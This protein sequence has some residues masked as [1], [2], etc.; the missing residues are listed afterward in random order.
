MTQK[1]RKNFDKTTTFIDKHGRNVLV[2]LL[3]YD[4]MKRNLTLIDFIDLNQH[5]INHLCYNK[6]P[7]CQC[8]GESPP[9]NTPSQRQL[10]TSQLDML[11]DKTGQKVEGHNSNRNIQKIIFLL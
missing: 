11:L 1:Q 7:G 3:E 10:Y 9:C 5:A 6:S 4:L 2:L 8:T